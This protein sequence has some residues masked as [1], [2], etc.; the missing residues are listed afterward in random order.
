MEKPI[1][2][3][4]PVPPKSA[5]CVQ[6]FNAG[7]YS[8]KSLKMT[9]ATSCP[10]PTYPLLPIEKATASVLPPP[11]KSIS[12]HQRFETPPWDTSMQEASLYSLSLLDLTQIEPD[13]L[14]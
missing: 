6:V 5:F 11:L 13:F 7:S 1:A 3:N 12:R 4:L 10:V 14:P 2:S 8:Q 9:A